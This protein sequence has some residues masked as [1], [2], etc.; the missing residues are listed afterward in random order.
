MVSVSTFINQYFGKTKQGN[1]PQ[2]LGQCV[3]LCSL[4]QDALGAPHEYGN[5]KDFLNDAD[6]ALFDVVT[7]DPNNYNQFPPVGAIMVWGSSW[8]NGFGHCGIVVLANGH[9]FTT[10]EQNDI[11]NVDLTGACEILNHANYSGVLG[12]LVFKQGVS[13]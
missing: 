3:G 8:G 12:W 10:F 7:N 1:T 4:W 9:S 13:A 11:T 5:A 6:K 2:N